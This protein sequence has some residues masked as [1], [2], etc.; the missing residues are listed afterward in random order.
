MRWIDASD[1]M[2]EKDDGDPDGDVLVRG[3]WNGKSYVLSRKWHEVQLGGEWLEGALS[4][5]PSKK[6]PVTL[7]MGM[8]NVEVMEADVRKAQTEVL[9]RAVS[10]ESRSLIDAILSWFCVKR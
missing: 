5:P 3:K 7:R 4:E 2:P 8:V 6:F 1:R 9:A 10:E